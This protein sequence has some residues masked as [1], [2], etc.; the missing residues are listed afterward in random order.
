MP[1]NTR[2][3]RSTRR[4]FLW[5][6]GLYC[7]DAKGNVA[8][9]RQ[10]GTLDSGWFYDRTY[11]WGF[12]SSPLIFSGKVIVQCDIQDGSFIE[13][14]DLQTGERPHGRRSETRSNVE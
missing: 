1:T 6:N 7:Y 11:Q 9:K 5:G 8:W 3:R 2:Y 10:L 12:G 4:G 13:A 14:I